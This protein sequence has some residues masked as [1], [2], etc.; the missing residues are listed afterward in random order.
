MT[1][2]EKVQ[3]LRKKAGMSQDA[4][5]ERLEVSRQAVSKWERDEA[6]PETEKVVRIAKLFEVSLDELLLDIKEEPEPETQPWYEAPRYQTRTVTPE[7]RLEQFLRRHGYKFGYAMMAV[8]GLICAFAILMR[9]LWPV[10]AGNFFDSAMSDPF[11]TTQWEVSMPYDL[12]ESVKQ[13]VMSQ[14]EEEL[15]MST[16]YGSSFQQMSSITNSAL[17]TQANLFLIPLLPG[18]V[19]LIGGVVI[20]SKGKKLAAQEMQ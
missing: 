8:G 14:M 20:V 17:K 13:E 19:L 2:G 5:A 18:L 9:L 10:L 16:F 1:F 4:L 3:N 7:A 15:G 6:M 12:P 11:G